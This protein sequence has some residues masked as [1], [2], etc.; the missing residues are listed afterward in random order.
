MRA[1]KTLRRDSGL[2]GGD[3]AGAEVHERRAYP[4]HGGASHHQRRPERDRGLQHGP[5][6]RAKPLVVQLRDSQVHG[7]ISHH[8]RASLPLERRRAV[9]RS[10]ACRRRQRPVPVPSP[11]VPRRQISHGAP[12]REVLSLLFELPIQFRQIFHNRWAAV[13]THAAQHDRLRRRLQQFDATNVGADQLVCALIHDAHKLHA[14]TDAR[15]ARHRQH[16]NHIRGWCLQCQSG[17][18]S[19]RQRCSTS[20]VHDYGTQHRRHSCHT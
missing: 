12:P 5:E 19:E 4:T 2:G 20:V 9:G 6:P 8:N 3:D 14:P 13:T 10:G 11:R 17:V 18:A 7:A 1:Y 16:R 15:P